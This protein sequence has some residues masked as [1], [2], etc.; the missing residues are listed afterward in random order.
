M[1]EC[2]TVPPGRQSFAARYR[3]TSVW[4]RTL[5]GHKGP[6]KRPRRIA[7]PLLIPVLIGIPVVVGGGWIV[8][9]VIAG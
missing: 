9:R 7:M 8:Y 3:G 4:P 2:G 6:N 5:F 1:L